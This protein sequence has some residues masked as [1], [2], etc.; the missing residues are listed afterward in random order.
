MLS[1]SFSTSS[2]SLRV[3]ALA[4]VE[5]REDALVGNLAVEDD[6]RVT[7]ALELFE[8]D[9]VHAAAGVDQ[10]GGDDRERAALLDVA[11]RAEEALGALQGV[12]VDTAGQHL[13]GARH[14]RVVGAA[15]AGDRDRAG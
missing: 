9:L 6:F 3:P 10:G 11:R 5:R 4:D 15:E 1:L 7:G 2:S 13:A 12:G 8:D 14:D